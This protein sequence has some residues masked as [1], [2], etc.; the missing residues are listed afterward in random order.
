[1]CKQCRQRKC[2]PPQCT[3][4]TPRHTS[5]VSPSR[6]QRMTQL[7]LKRSG[8][9]LAAGL[10]ETTSLTVTGGVAMLREVEEEASAYSPNV[11]STARV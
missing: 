3:A 10:T 2:P 11:H 9:V 8:I 1:M 7:Q 4:G 6:N 5:L